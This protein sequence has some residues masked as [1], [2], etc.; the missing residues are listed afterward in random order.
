MVASERLGQESYRSPGHRPSDTPTTPKQEEFKKNMEQ[1][2]QLLL[3]SGIPND[4]D[5]IEGFKKIG[6]KI[7]FF[8]T[9]EEKK[10]YAL[11]ADEAGVT[12]DSDQYVHDWLLGNVGTLS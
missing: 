8:L 2:K 9:S 11:K 3:Y 6:G 4:K 7:I 10:L 5:D 12:W 1:T